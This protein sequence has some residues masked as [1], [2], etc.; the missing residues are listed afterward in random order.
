MKAKVFAFLQRIPAGKVAT[1]GQIAAFLGS[2][3]LARAVGNILHSNINPELYPCHRVVNSRGQV[4]QNY[5]FG[6]GAAQ[7]ARLES[8][9]VVFEKNGTIDLQKYGV[10]NMGEETL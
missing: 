3:N 6:G 2:R 4:A 8:E 1:Y 9:G 5:A 10:E 7:R